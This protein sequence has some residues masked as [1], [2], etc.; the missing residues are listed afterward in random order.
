ML[1]QFRQVW[2]KRGIADVERWR[3]LR[4]NRVHRLHGA[5]ADERPPPGEHLV[6]DDAE[7]E[8]VGAMI[9]RRATYLFRRH[10]ADRAEHDSGG[11]VES[12]HRR[13]R[14]LRQRRRQPRQPEVEHLHATVIGQEDVLGFDVAMDDA[15]VMSGA[16]R[17]HDL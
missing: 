13:A 5:V 12:R 6:E 3:I 17:A 8:D 15:L 2:S 4:E 1:E 7:G 9:R 16:K 14:R 10:V 11:R